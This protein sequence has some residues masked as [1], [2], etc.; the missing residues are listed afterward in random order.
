MIFMHNTPHTDTG[1]PHTHINRK[2]TNPAVYMPPYGYAYS[3]TLHYRN[4]CCINSLYYSFDAQ[5]AVAV[6]TSATSFPPLPTR[7]THIP[8]KLC[9][10][11]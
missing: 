4:G 6:L 3:R 2:Y 8:I 10:S 5:I 7:H 11:P 1:P 9:S